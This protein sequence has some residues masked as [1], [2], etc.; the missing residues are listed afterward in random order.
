[1]PE[2]GRHKRSP[3]HRLGDLT[4][5]NH[6]GAV[7]LSGWA[8]DWSLGDASEYTLLQPHEELHLHCIW[9]DLTDASMHR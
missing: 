1:M 8:T 5:G 7:S 2:G 9:V 6:S 4:D 3:P